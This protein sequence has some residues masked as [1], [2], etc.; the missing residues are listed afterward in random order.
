L[1]ETEAPRSAAPQPETAQ[2]GLMSTIR[3]L[4]PGFVYVLTA[5]GAGDLVSNS[6]AGSGYGYAL[7]WTL[8]FTLVFRFVWVNVSAKYVLVS[9][10]SL[11]QGYA[12]MGRWVIWI[13]L[14]AGIITGHFSA[15]YSML[16]AG[17]I[18]DVLLP[19]P[20]EWSASIWSLAF[21]LLGFVMAYWGGYGLI[22][23]FCKILIAVMG[24]CLI[25]VAV[26]SK[27]D[28]VGILRGTFIPTIPGSQGLYSA[29][30]ILM[31]LVGTMAGSMTN[32]TYAYYIQEKGW[33]TVSHLRDQRF[34]LIFGVV[35]LFVMGA[36]LQIAAAAT[37]RPLGIELEDANDLVRIFSEVQGMVGLIIFSLGLWGAAFSTLLGTLVGYGFVVADLSN[38]ISK[39]SSM[40]ER[41]RE[42]PRRHPVYRACVIFWSVSPLYIL[43]T[44]VSPIFLVLIVNAMFV[45]LVPVLTP[46][47]LKLTNDRNLMGEYKNGWLTNA[48]LF[49]LL[50]VAVYITA[51]NAVEWLSQWF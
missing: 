35:C 10:E 1:T 43:L 31:A 8:A 3:R 16:M 11:A 41:F 50:L 51:A 32:L 15:M 33:K 27:P 44:G 37:V 28:V 24:A 12:R 45:L 20:T 48:I 36:L 47:L 30:L 9:G 4:G 23:T 13:I 40:R 49:A 34:D 38:F 18:A 39:D 42:N 25:V 14:I 29:L 26:I 2:T 17:N 7:I 21:V 19:F 22:E 46:I 6:A 5:L